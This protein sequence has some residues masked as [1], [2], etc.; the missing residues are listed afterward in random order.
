MTGARATV[1]VFV[2]LVITIIGGMV[3]LLTTR[4]APIQITILPPQPTASPEPSATPSP[5]TVYVTGA[6]NQPVA[7]SLTFPAGSRVEDAIAAAGGAAPNADLTRINLAAILRD[8]DQVYVPMIAET[9][10]VATP[11]NGGLIY[12]NTATQAEI[13][14]L[15]GVG[16]A[17]AERIIAYRAEH[18]RIASLDELDSIEGIGPAMLEDLRPLVSFE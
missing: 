16:P 10:V 11:N 8:G 5:V 3:L 1:V 9:V 2:M 13:E 15:P 7:N 6:V 4:P 17:L 18:G 14:T 12:I